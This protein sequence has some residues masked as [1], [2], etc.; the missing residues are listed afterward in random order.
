MVRRVKGALFLGM[1][2]TG[3]IGFF[4]GMFDYNGITSTPPAPVF[5]DLDV[6]GVFSHGLYTVVF[7]FLFVTIF[8]STGTL[9][10]VAELAVFITS[11]HM[12]RATSSLL[13]VA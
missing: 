12:S 6:T 4:T 1:I 11:S 9:I 2:I 3:V 10:G 13:V 5:F 7:S 8:D